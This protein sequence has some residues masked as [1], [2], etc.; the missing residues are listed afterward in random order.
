M[1]LLKDAENSNFHSTVLELLTEHGFD[2]MAQALTVLFNEAMKIERQQFLQAEPFERATGR[3]GYANGFKGKSLKSRV[4]ILNLQI[5]QVRDLP[6]GMPNFYPQS[7]ERGL[8]SERALK[9]ALAEMYLKGVAR[10]RSRTLRKSSAV[11]K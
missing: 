7:V 1:T 5:P 2:G 11:S 10:A 9:I 6:A 4:G 8:R 3:V